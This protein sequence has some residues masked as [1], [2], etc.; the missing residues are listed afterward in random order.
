MKFILFCIIKE[1]AIYLEKGVANEKYN[2]FNDQLDKSRFM[3]YLIVHTTL[4]KILDV[5]A[6]VA[7]LALAAIEP[8]AMLGMDVPIWVCI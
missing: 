3:C 1:A 5:V 7:L 4:Y 6:S 8:P 2:E